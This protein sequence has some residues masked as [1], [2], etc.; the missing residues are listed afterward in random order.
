MGNAEISILHHH[1]NTKFHLYSLHYLI[2]SDMYTQQ[3]CNTTKEAQLPI[4]FSFFNGYQLNLT[5]TV[6]KI[7]KL[8]QSC[9]TTVVKINLKQT[10][11]FL[12][13]THQINIQYFCLPLLEVSIDSGVVT[14]IVTHSVKLLH[15]SFLFL[16]SFHLLPKE[17]LK[18]IIFNNKYAAIK[19]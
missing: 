9:Y 18:I 17:K 12:V 3:Y 14:V 1:T 2:C 6:I 10:L 19:L 5:E 4:T 8:K 7:Y 16:F 13:S 15:S 11:H